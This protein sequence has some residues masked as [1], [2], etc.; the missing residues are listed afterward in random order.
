MPKQ[1]NTPAPTG[2]GSKAK[3]KVSKGLGVG[4]ETCHLC[5]KEG[6]VTYSYGNFYSVG[7]PLNHGFMLCPECRELLA[8]DASEFTRRWNDVYAERYA[9]KGGKHA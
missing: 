7:I 1:R 2:E 8:T 5:L 6:P 4:G 9:Y 3:R